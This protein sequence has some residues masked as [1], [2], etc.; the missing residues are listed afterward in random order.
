[1][2]NLLSRPPFAALPAPR[3]D[4]HR[5]R[6]A[7]RIL[8]AAL[9]ALVA[10][11][12]GCSSLDVKKTT[13]TQT[14]AARKGPE[15][16]PVRSLTGFSE[17]LACMD[18]TFI[19][20]GI[21][22]VS[23]LVEDIADQ[24]KKVNAGTKD[25]LISAVSDMT[26]RS[27]AVK[28]I[29]F[30]QDSGNLI[31]FLQQAERK[32]VYQVVPQYDIK[33]SITQWDENV[34]QNQRDFGL[35]F[36]SNSFGMNIGLA[37]DVA[38]SI[39]GL[40]LSMLS[41][42]DLSLLNGVTA[43]NSIIVFKEGKGYDSDARISKFGIN[44]NISFSKSEGQSQA[45]RT[46]VELAAIE[47]LGKLTKTPYWTCLGAKPGEASVESQISEWFDAMYGHPE[48]LVGYFQ[49]Q[50]RTR[51]YYAGAVDG[52]VNPQIILAVRAYRSALGLTDEP[53]LDLD[54]LKA[55]LNADHAKVL[56]SNP[57]PESETAESATPAASADPA[58]AAP[59]TP[60]KP[61]P[62]SLAI[63]SAKAGIDRYAP[64]ESLALRV[65]PSR[66]AHLYCY[67]QDETRQIMRFFP[68]RFAKDSL[69]KPGT[70]LALPNNAQFEIFANDKRETETI[71]CFA[72]EEDLA[73][74]LPAQALGADFEY[75]PVKSLQA[76]RD[77]FL[78]A[79]E[80]H[81]AEG[82]YRVEFK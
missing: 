6:P 40:D 32:S 80:G 60:A 78:I 24:T 13:T 69:V 35:G 56:A 74:R 36:D 67:M 31:S 16:R 15:S 29:A 57:P 42:A 27:R 3:S 43:R 19:D 45:L 75:L 38:A 8:S 2:N 33:G 34:I 65:T 26:R 51:G 23:V 77:L 61:A 11:V 7:P 18:R 1:M 55:Y 70:P 73:K 47:L 25:M 54:F 41:T 68:N 14:E 21:R 20:Y 58:P 63:A 44:F 4:R 64:G 28:L 37:R 10:L 50:L 48:E 30:G 22:D 66:E 59:K 72:A 76:L 79:A 81:I 53:R 82:V 17:A 5:L 49:A 9:L 46:L 52:K 62:L 71:V 12:S 39:L